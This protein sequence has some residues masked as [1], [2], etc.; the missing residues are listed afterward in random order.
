M[1]SPAWEV[2]NVELPFP[3]ASMDPTS[4]GDA[5]AADAGFLIYPPAGGDSQPLFVSSAEVWFDLKELVSTALNFVPI[6]GQVKGAAEAAIGQDLVSGRQL[7]GW[8]RV[9]NVASVIPH[10]H[11][12]KGIAKTIGEIGHFAH[13]AN[14]V[15]HAKHGVDVYLGSP[16]SGGDTPQ[17]APT[18]GGDPLETGT[19]RLPH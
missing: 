1:G 19:G 4:G 11:G 15:V 17:P 12:A 14:M 2:S 6:L 18:S 13:Q 16:D 3:V 7:A 10:L 5:L 9:L 8:E